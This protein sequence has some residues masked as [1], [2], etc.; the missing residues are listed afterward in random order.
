[1]KLEH[2]NQRA[3]VCLV[4]SIALI[5]SCL[6]TVV[7]AEGAPVGFA[8][9][10][11][12]YRAIVN[13]S[14]RPSQKQLEMPAFRTEQAQKI[15]VKPTTEA[16]PLFGSKDQGSLLLKKLEFDGNTI[17]SRQELQ[18]L[19]QSFLNRRLTAQDLEELRGR[20]TTAYVNAGYIN[21]GA[22]I[23]PQS[24]AGGVLRLSIIEGKLT[25]IRLEGMGRLRENYVS[26][27][28]LI[29]A[30]SPLN[31][32]NLQKS[33][34]LLLSDPLIKQLNGDLLPKDRLGESVLNVKVTRARPYQ[35]YAGADNYT[36]PSVGGYT[37]R[38]G[39]WVDNLTGFGERIAGDFMI[40]GGSLGFNTSIDIPL[41]AYDTHAIFRY[42]NTHTSLIEKPVNDSNIK[43]HVIGYE[44]GLSQPIY[45][46]AGIDVRTGI[47]LSVRES[48]SSFQDI[49]YSFTEGMPWGQGKVKV[50]ALRM[51]QQYAQQGADNAFVFRSTFSKG[52]HAF[53]ATIQNDP[54]L[55]SGNFFSWLGQTQYTHVV[56]DNGANLVFRGGT[57]LTGDSLLPLERFS[58]GGVYTVRGYRE[59][60]YVRDNGFNVGLDFRYPLFGGEQGAEHSLF[61]V[62]FM[63]YGGAWNNATLSDLKPS[64][65]YL[66]SAGIGLSWH[67]Q[68]VSTE[69]YWAH[70][71]ARVALTTTR[72][73]QDEGFHFRVNCVAF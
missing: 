63:D 13:D 14:T 16:K 12:P 38:V 31:F 48:N 4:N 35:L 19:T 37:G 40:T 59:N 73:I 33:Y 64:K 69:F 17:F 28:L 8:G 43:T 55:P 9:A 60:F 21:S 56:M 20:I 68:R 57:Q 36:T 62:P 1:M 66:H 54:L 29:G 41:N 50:S 32:K 70:D 24:A 5:T 52:I 22:I 15:L 49:P 25:E 30:G 34:Q 10:N 7:A 67:Y 11:I 51:W 44:G 6:S 27:R 23:Q 42:S 46:D 72:D 58:V 53:G 65:S 18:N 45:R 61:L 26:D 71:I 47:S 2:K 39:G 3:R